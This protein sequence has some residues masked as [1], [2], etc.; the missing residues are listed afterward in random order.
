MSGVYVASLDGKETKRLLAADS[1]ALYAPAPAGG[2]YL[3]FARDGALLAQPFDAGRLSLSGEPVRIADQV[4]VNA[5]N[6][7]FFSASDNG[8]LVYDPS[9][10][11]ENRQLTWFDRA[12]DF[13]SDALHVVE[14]YTPRSAD[15]LN[16]EATIEDSKTFSRPWKIS[17]PLYRRLE[18]NAQLM[19]F[20][21]VEFVEELLYGA[22]RKKP[23][24]K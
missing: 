16:Y 24:S 19:D 20:K 13:H 14:R 23:L 21:C 9:G 4:R 8:T 15:I 6:R 22:Y 17:M 12:G 11:T 2:G 7:G 10:D 1:S 3:L 18:K 5:N